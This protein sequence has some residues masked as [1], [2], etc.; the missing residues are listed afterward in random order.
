[1]WKHSHC[2]VSLSPTLSPSS[3]QLLSWWLL[4]YLAPLGGLSPPP[5][6][7]HSLLRTSGSMAFFNFFFFPWHILL[8][9]LRW[10]C[11]PG[12]RV[13]KRSPYWFLQSLFLVCPVTQIGTPQRGADL[14]SIS[15]LFLPLAPFPVC[16]PRISLKFHFPGAPG[17]GQPF[18][19]GP[20]WPPW[21]RQP[22]MGLFHLLP[23]AQICP[24]HPLT[25]F[26]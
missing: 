24:H 16:F 10:L 8:L 23:W 20:Q 2:H 12:V 11:E 17:E 26:S 14:G 1:M 6:H 3:T 9:I 18:W 21:K 22:A 19:I 4:T 5:L 7:P 15:P 13:W 25:G